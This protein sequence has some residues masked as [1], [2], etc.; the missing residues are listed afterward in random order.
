MK[1]LILTFAAFFLCSTGLFAAE[2]EPS[3]VIKSPGDF[4]VVFDVSPKSGQG[5]VLLYAKKYNVAL[6]SIYMPAQN[7]FYPNGGNASEFMRLTKIAT[8][9]KAYPQTIELEYEE[10]GS[11]YNYSVSK[12]DFSVREKMTAVVPSRFDN[13]P[14]YTNY[15]GTQLSDDQFKKLVSE[16]VNFGAIKKAIK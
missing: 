10:S 13:G 5:Y 9:V 4:A 2:L 6:R 11:I 7:D 1:K 15:P 16:A 14:I 8:S 12:S 3:K